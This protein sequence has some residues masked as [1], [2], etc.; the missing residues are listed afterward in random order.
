LRRTPPV[1]IGRISTKNLNG[2]LVSDA[3]LISGDSGGPLFDLDGKVVGVHSSISTSLTFNRCA[4]VSAAQADWAKLL[5]GERWGRLGGIAGGP[6]ERGG[7][8][9]KAVI[10]ASLDPDSTDGA[11]VLE[12]HRQSPLAAAGLQAG[13]VITKVEGEEVHTSDALVSRLGK[14]KPG[15]KVQIV[16][17][18]GEEERRAEVALISRREMNKRLGLGF[19]DRPRRGRRNAPEPDSDAR[20]ARR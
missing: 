15:E 8:L 14:A 3:T 19:E 11:A 6:P 12:V 7:E 16:Y 17:R 10:G 18:R 9:T 2:Y 20:P 4:P 5:A 1:R 13:D